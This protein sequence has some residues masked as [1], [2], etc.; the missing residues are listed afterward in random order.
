M[1]P[2]NDVVFCSN[3]ARLVPSMDFEMRRR[4]LNKQLQE[5]I[6]KDNEP[7]LCG[8]KKKKKKKKKKEA[9]SDDL[10][11]TRIHKRNCTIFFWKFE[12]I[13]I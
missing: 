9:P 10:V 7:V 1:V 6:E 13:V 4:Q 11:M 12:A 3:L 2:K 8:K 5:E